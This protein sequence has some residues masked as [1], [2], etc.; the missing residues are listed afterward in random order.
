MSTSHPEV[1]SHLKSSKVSDQLLLSDFL[2]Q[3]YHQQILKLLLPNGVLLK[4]RTMQKGELNLKISWVAIR[5]AELDFDLSQLRK[6]HLETPNIIRNWYCLWLESQMMTSFMQSRRTWVC[7]DSGL[8]GVITSNLI[9]FCNYLL[10]TP[11]N[12]LSFYLGAT[13]ETV[14]S[15]SNLYR[16]DIVPVL[17]VFFVLNNFEN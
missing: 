17:C 5:L 11:Q 7:K 6:L 14:L 13:Y 10:A 15:L 8:D 4:Q 1:I 9:C 16:W 12:L 2:M 3:M